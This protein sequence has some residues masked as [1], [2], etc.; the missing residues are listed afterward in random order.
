MIKIS[1]TPK[2]W[3]VSVYLLRFGEPDTSGDIYTK[4]SINTKALESMIIAGMI[5][6]YQ[7]DD[8]GVI[9]TLETSNA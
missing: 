6:S 5:E 7:I 8:K 1:S 4:D 2:T 3:L 9:V